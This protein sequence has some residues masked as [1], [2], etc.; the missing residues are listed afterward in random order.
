MANDKA[1][2][3]GS[4]N[5]KAIMDAVISF[6]A[7]F[8]PITLVRRTL[9]LVLIAA[10]LDNDTIHRL[11][12]YGHS[13]IRKL[14]ADM[15]EKSVPDL[16]TIRGGG[17]KA[18]LSGIEDE[19]LSE[20]ESGNYHTRQQVA[21]MIKDKF[22]ISISVSAV[23]KF[24]KKRLQKAKVRVDPSQGRRRCAG[25]LLPW[26]TAAL[27]G[28]GGRWDI[29][30]PLHGRIPFRYG[31]RISGIHLLQSASFC[32]VFFRKDAL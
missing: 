22:G 31:L 24:L 11:T 28:K 32:K 30:A 21:D 23:G 27:D 6:L 7:V 20:L 3:T 5:S 4:I 12:G 15:R 26:R 16:L 8:M 18:K 9:S 17:R 13:T 1:V 29:C 2:P 25:K 19:I 14:K 10:G